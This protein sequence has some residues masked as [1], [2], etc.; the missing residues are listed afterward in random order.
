MGSM[1]FTPVSDEGHG[2]LE[3]EPP[4]DELPEIEPDVLEPDTLDGEVW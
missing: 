3:F 2:F 1:S 4:A